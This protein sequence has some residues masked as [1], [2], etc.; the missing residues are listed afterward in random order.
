MVADKLGGVFK[1]DLRMCTIAGRYKGAAGAIRDLCFDESGT[2]VACCG[3][4]RFLRLYNF[5]TRKQLLKVYMKQ[6][7]NRVLISNEAV[8]VEQPEK[9]EDDELWDSIP[10]VGIDPVST[11]NSSYKRTLDSVDSQETTSKKIRPS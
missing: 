2:V 6:R 4:D 10:V 1:I 3:L 9:S 5:D 8:P 7:L 11:T